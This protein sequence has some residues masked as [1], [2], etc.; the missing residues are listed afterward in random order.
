MV[1]IFTDA[2]NDDDVH[3]EHFSEIRN[4]RGTY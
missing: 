4:E 3:L 2:N 1:Q